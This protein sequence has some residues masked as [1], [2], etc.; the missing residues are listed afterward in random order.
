[1]EKIEILQ[2]QSQATLRNCKSDLVN[3]LKSLKNQIEIELENINQ[4]N[5]KPNPNGIIQNDGQVI[6]ILCTKIATIQ[7]ILNNINS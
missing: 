3:K 6:D 5:Y 1:M 4:E 7:D 2:V